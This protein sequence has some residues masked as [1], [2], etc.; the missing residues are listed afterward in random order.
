MAD[1]IDSGIDRKKIL[2]EIGASAP[3]P[4]PAPPPRHASL[5]PRDIPASALSA[6]AP[7]TLPVEEAPPEPARRPKSRW[8]RHRRHIA[9]L[10][11]LFVALLWFGVGLATEE[12][13]PFALG[14]IFVGLAVL[15]WVGS[16]VRET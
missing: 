10:V 7:P 11:L 8:Q 2:D 6:M 14:G 4:E 15:I 16:L 5:P 9:T 12:A 3:L 1:E 13:L